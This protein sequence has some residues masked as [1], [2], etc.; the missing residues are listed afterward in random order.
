MCKMHHDRPLIGSRL[1]LKLNHP[2]KVDFLHLDDFGILQ[3]GL[4]AGRVAFTK[5]T[6]AVSSEGRSR[7][8]SG[9]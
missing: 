8:R 4:A 5:A 9:D 7:N 1:S 3:V 2:V 6:F